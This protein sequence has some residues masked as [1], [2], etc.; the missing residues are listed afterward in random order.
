MTHPYWQ[1]YKELAASANLRSCWSTPVFDS[2]GNVM[3]TFAMYSRRPKTPDE[4]EIGFLRTTAKL[5]GLII[6]QRRAEERLRYLA[7]HD[8]LTGLPNRSSLIK[9]LEDDL[10][11]ADKPPFALLFLDLDHF[12][13]VNDTLGHVIGD[14]LLVAVT[15]RLETNTGNS[16]FCARLGG[17]E[18]AVLI[19]CYGGTQVIDQTASNLIKAITAPY[20]IDG[21]ALNIGV[22]IGIAIA[23]GTIHSN[24]EL[25]RQA[26]AALY[27]VKESG[28]N[29]FLHFDP[30]MVRRIEKENA[31]RHSLSEAIEARKDISLVY[32]PQ[33]ELSTGKV[34][35]C[36]ALCRWNLDGG[37][38][39]PPPVFIDLA[40]R[41]GLIRPLSVLIIQTAIKQALAWREQG[42]EIN[43]ALNL[44][45][46]LFIDYPFISF[47][48]EAIAEA[49]LPSRLFS[50]EITESILV[51]DVEAAIATIDRLNAHGY[52]TSID[53]FGTGYSSLNYLTQFDLDKLKLDR[54]F[55]QDV[56]ASES[57]ARVVRSVIGLGHGLNMRIVAEG[58]ETQEQI[59]FLKNYGCD[60]V[61][62]FY[63][64][65]PMPGDQFLDWVHEQSEKLLADSTK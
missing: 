43:M 58:A 8:S 54:S 42:F 49:G 48:I 26:D 60:I 50:C 59:D 30:E 55:I 25:M 28:R 46:S 9:K 23:D 14:S 39:V 27:A 53:D 36:E 1:N 17:D 61:Q 62:G 63:F 37:K 52:T 32:Q 29:G 10:A 35:G 34:V 64:A 65:R 16:A 40:E 20:M 33:V 5:A 24:V 21:N 22:S 4:W 18:F 57:S 44:P 41:K 12:K 15:N 6:Q 3:A 31:L 38:P 45:A 19:R 47:M 7:E 56:I 2:Q 51:T 11:I 13:E